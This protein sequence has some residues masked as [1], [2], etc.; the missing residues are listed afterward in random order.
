MC[1]R[2]TDN[3]GNLLAASGLLESRTYRS[4]WRNRTNYDRLRLRLYIWMSR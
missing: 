4:R 3:D 1:H 2:W